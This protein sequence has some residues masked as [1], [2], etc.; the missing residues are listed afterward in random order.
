MI[1]VP[2][3]LAIFIILV[4]MRSSRGRKPALISLIII[5][6]ALCVVLPL[7]IVVH[8]LIYLKQYSS[9]FPAVLLYLLFG[10]AFTGA[11]EEYYPRFK[12]KTDEQYKAETFID[13]WNIEENIKDGRVLLTINNIFFV[14]HVVYLVAILLLL[15]FLVLHLST[16]IVGVTIGVAAFFTLFFLIWFRWY[17]KC[18]YC[19]NTIYGL[20]TRRM[21]SYSK[22]LYIS[23]M[24]RLLKYHRFTC[25]Y[26]HGHFSLG[27]KDKIKEKGLVIE[28]KHEPDFSVIKKRD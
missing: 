18:P 12:Y 6:Y 19:K 16:W 2:S 10:L 17:F 11:V 9:I 21:T 20:E 1:G 27:I 23:T 15:L 13:G 24:L 5:L 25:M 22:P 28:N 26:C 8:S 4:L 7:A 14:V 3:A